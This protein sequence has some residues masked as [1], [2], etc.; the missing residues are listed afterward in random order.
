MKQYIPPAN[1][2]KVNLTEKKA[3]NVENDY[4]VA[5]TG[6]QKYEESQID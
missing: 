6:E 2:N 4:D 3:T 5:S 1:R